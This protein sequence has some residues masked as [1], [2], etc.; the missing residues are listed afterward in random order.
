TNSNVQAI[1]PNNHNNEDPIEL[2][3]QTIKPNDDEDWKSNV[4]SI[5]LSDQ[6]IKDPINP[7]FQTRA[8]LSDIQINSVT[9]SHPG[10]YS[11]GNPHPNHKTVAK[12]LGLDTE[13]QRKIPEIRSEIQAKSETKN[14][15]THN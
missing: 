14:S 7:D 2:N 10:I 1:E 3:L 12:K 9:P 4:Q 8:L 6:A 11:P 15:P 5:E 13:Q